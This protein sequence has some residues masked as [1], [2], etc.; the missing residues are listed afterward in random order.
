MSNTVTVLGNLGHTPELKFTKSGQPCCQFGV[1]DNQRAG[2]GQDMTQW[3]TCT[4]FGRDAELICQYF[5]TGKPILVTGKMQMRWYKKRDG[6]QG[7]SL[8]VIVGTWD[9]VN[10]GGGERRLDDPAD[11]VPPAPRGTTSTTDTAAG[12]P[13][14]DEVPDISDPFADQ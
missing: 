7:V 4:A 1:A 12:T 6:T 11:P 2:D 10:V 3:W 9:F 5:S 13:A 8:D 14:T